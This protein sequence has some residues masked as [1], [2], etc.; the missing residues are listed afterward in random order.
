M[1]T[2]SHGYA[3]FVVV[4]VAVLMA[5]ALA[6]GCPHPCNCRPRAEG[7]GTIVDCRGR[8]L[9]SVVSE[10]PANATELDMGEN[11]IGFVNRSSFPASSKLRVLRLDGCRLDRLDSRVF[12]N[13]QQLETLDLSR[14]PI[15]VVNPSTLFGLTHLRVLNLSGSGI[16]T[17][18]EYVFRSV[19][20]TELD[21]S[22]NELQEIPND[23]F[24][25]VKA[26][27]TLNL[28]GNRL[29][30]LGR[31]F[32]IPLEQY[33]RTLSVSNNR[34]PLTIASDTFAGANLTTLLLANSGVSDVSF[35]GNTKA[36][37][38]DL[39]GNN[40]TSFTLQ[41]G[42][43][44]L[45]RS[46]REFILRDVRLESLDDSFFTS[47]PLLERLDLS[48]NLLTSFRPDLFLHMQNLRFVDFSRNRFVRIP[49]KFGPQMNS[50]ESLNFSHCEIASINWANL[51]TMVHLDSLDLSG[52]RLQVIPENASSL[53]NSITTL[54]LSQNPWHCNCEMQWFRRWLATNMRSVDGPMNCSSPQEGVPM[55]D[56]DPA[57]YVCTPATI[58]RITPS[59]S[60][61]EGDVVTLSCAA[62]S[63]PAPAIVWRAPFGDVLS[64][65][66]PDDRTQT[67]TIAVFSIHQIKPHQSGWFSC[68]ATNLLRT[69]ITYTYVQVVT[70][71][72]ELADLGD[73]EFPMTPSRRPRQSTMGAFT[74]SPPMDLD[75]VTT[76]RGTGEESAS[77]TSTSAP[78][79]EHL[80]R[81]IDTTTKTDEEILETVTR[82]TDD[83]D[84]VDGYWKLPGTSSVQS[85]SAVTSVREGTSPPGSPTAPKAAD[86]GYSS[87]RSAGGAGATDAEAQSTFRDPVVVTAVILGVLV[88]SVVVVVTV[89]VV[90][91]RRRHRDYPVKEKQR[92]ASRDDVSEKTKL[93]MSNLDDSCYSSTATDP[94]NPS[95]SRIQLAED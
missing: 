7:V 9:T 11:T 51:S 36:G 93:Q 25:S 62:Q 91:R 58:T 75:A 95:A 73:L 64:I 30:S 46:C 39:S 55:L 5:T 16:Q 45:A 84:E 81:S 27:Q 69:S 8:G 78:T 79:S 70:S 49:D 41:R 26:I 43:D 31:Q 87:E 57:D 44:D 61:M 13:L 94:M 24:R 38:V 3:A 33:I 17:L 32:L 29:F 1:T 22:E 90:Y 37:R 52:N 40:L 74:S 50:L 82:E 80:P 54:R 60:R 83:V 76:D 42:S 10:L 34:N 72:E 35:L 68:N 14:N 71:A 53:L 67:K 18:P 48:G 66:P 85:S 15:R 89:F 19:N 92:R 6:S 47:L 4:V 77:L 63:D 20:L 59:Q 88:T 12:R 86:E 23:L 21:L 28:D 56:L 2:R 65:T